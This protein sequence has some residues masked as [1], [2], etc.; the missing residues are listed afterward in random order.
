MVSETFSLWQRICVCSKVVSG[1]SCVAQEE[2]FSA[3]A[4]L[5]REVPAVILRVGQ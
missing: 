3:S 4:F 2:G 1:G 5:S